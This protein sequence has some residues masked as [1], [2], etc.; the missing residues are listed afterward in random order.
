[1]TTTISATP[2][3]VWTQREIVEL[4]RA[5]EPATGVIT[6][7]GAFSARFSQEECFDKLIELGV[8]PK[9][10]AEK[11]DEAQRV[12]VERF[13]RT[14]IVQATTHGQALLTARFALKTIRECGVLPKRRKAAE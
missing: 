1:M 13:V 9:P 11:L 7:V 10:E 5:F 4:I 12:A 8:M 14:H 6:L 2:R 3:R